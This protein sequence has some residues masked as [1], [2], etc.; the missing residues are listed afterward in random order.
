MDK[1]GMMCNAGLTAT[2][3]KCVVQVLKDPGDK[4]PV[5]LKE[6]EDFISHHSAMLG[7]AR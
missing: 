5:D 7:H 6:F 4:K 1:S 3:A 2:G